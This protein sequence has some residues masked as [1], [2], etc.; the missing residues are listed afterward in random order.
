MPRKAMN[1]NA[2]EPIVAA[3]APK[4]RVAATERAERPKG[5]STAMRA[6]GGRPTNKYG[7]KRVE[8]DGVT[9]AS[10]REAA[11]WK[12]LQLLE[13]AGAIRDLM[14]QVSYDLNAEGGNLVGRYVADH[15]Y[16]EETPDGW[17][18][19]VEDVKGMP[20]PLYEWKRRHMAAQYGIEIREVR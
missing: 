10:K 4:S 2:G 19:V 20:T 6:T 11:R 15:V 12:A 14:R 1:V 16:R 7:A 17:E 13:R 3:D 18:L 8:Q 9:F 5:A